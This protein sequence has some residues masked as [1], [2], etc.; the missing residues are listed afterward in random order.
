MVPIGIHGADQLP[1]ADVKILAL[2][3]VNPLN[4]GNRLWGSP[5]AQT[6]GKGQE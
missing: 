5:V 1:Q 2:A 3:E 6:P 4:F